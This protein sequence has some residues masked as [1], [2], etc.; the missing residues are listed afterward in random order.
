MIAILLPILELAVLAALGLMVGAMIYTSFVEIPVRQKLD[1][2]AQLLNWQLVFRVASGF[3]KPFGIGLFPLFLVV[4]FL[5]GNWLWGLSAALLI[6]IQPFT[7]LFIAKTNAALIEINPKEATEA[8][9]TLI[10]GWD[11]L[12]HMRTVLITSSFT[13]ALIAH[14]QTA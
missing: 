9:K 2:P 10:R 8:T 12:H 13:I 11:R 3:L 5:S 6:A 7:A 4:W 14:V 1:G